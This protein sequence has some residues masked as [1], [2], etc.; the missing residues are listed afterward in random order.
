M[1][2]DLSTLSGKNKTKGQDRIGKGF[3]HQEIGLTKKFGAKEKEK[4]YKDLAT[5]LGA[6]VDFKTALDILANQQKKEFIRDLILGIKNK[7]I[8]GKNFYE[9]LEETNRFS[10]YEYYS[11]KIGEET[12]KLDAVLMELHKYFK[13]QLKLKK[14]IIAVITYPSFVLLLTVGVLYFM[15]SYVVP[16]FGSVFQQFDGE[17]PALTKK[18]MLL[19]E[20]FPLI[21]GIGIV[22]LLTVVLLIRLYKKHPTYR[23]YQAQVLLKIPFFGR[24]IKMV[25]L[26][27]YCQFLDLLLTARTPLT[28]SLEMVKKVIGFYPIETSIDTIRTDVIRGT[29]FAAAMKK[30]RIYEYKLTSMVAVA[31]EINQLDTMFARLADEY[32]EEVE[33]KTKMIGVILEPIIIIV[34]GLIVG[35]IMVAMYAPMFDLSKIIRGG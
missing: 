11:I 23:R 27:R 22:V 15:L 30:H 5:L 12:K 8:K 19:S 2:V 31:E 13:R 10:P 1:E 3:L 17:L 33:H 20:K 9:A 14:Q 16:M 26:A 4:L 28:D 7:I 24:L 29:S 32:D 34:I 35:V 21:L 25:Y 18:I 6:G